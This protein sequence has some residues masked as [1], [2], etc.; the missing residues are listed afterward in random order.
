M[1]GDY[2]HELVTRL[3]SEAKREGTLTESAALRVENQFRVEYQ[4]ARYVIS[5]N[6]VRRYEK[7]NA[8]VKEYINNDPVDM[9][10]KRHGVSRATIYRYLK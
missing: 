7:K 1:Q 4:G 9:I 5:V 8:I 6:P 2:I 3:V 10:K